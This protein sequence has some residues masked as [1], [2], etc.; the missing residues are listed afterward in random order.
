MNTPFAP[1]ADLPEDREF[2]LALASLSAARGV[3]PENL[4]ILSE[5]VVKLPNLGTEFALYKVLDTETGESGPVV[6]SGE[7]KPIDHEE[8]LKKERALEYEKRGTMQP[9][10]YHL[11]GLDEA[12]TVPVLIQFAVPEE[13]VDKSK[14]ENV[15]S[16]A[17]LS[18]RDQEVVDRVSQQ[19]AELF[20]ETLA[21]FGLETDEVVRPSGPF[22]STE[23]PAEVILKLSKDPRV[24]F[25]GPDQ[26][27]EILDYPTIPDSLP[28][29]RTD[30]V[31][32]T[33]T[34]GSGVK[35]AV[36]E[37][38]T[39]TVSQSC[40]NIGAIRTTSGSGSSHMTK[41][42]GIIGNRYN[43]GTCSGPWEGYAPEA[44]VLVANGSDY[45]D[46][47]QWA[48][49][50]GVN[51]V[52][53]SWHFGDEETSGS[54][55]SRD[56]YFDYWAVHYPYPAVFTSAGN[57]APGDFA[58]G[59]GYNFFGVGNVENDGDGDR[60]ND[61]ISSSSSYKNPASP[62]GDREIPEIAAPGSRHDLLGSSFGGTSCATPVAASIAALLMSANTSLKGW[63]EAIRVILLAT[64]NYQGA[65]GANWSKY[66]EGKD[67]TGMI[68]TRYAYHTAKRR[69]TGTTAQFRAHDYGSIQASDFSGG[70]FTK[71]W[72]AKT[73]TTQSRIRVAFMWNSKTSAS[74]SGPTS[75]VLDADLDLWVYDPSMN[76]V[77][78]SASYDSNYEFVEFTPQQ[79]GNYT[80]K[81]RGWS[82]PSSFWSY[83]GVAWTTHYDLCP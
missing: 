74:G 53:M 17:E 60:C 16:L 81:I 13:Q 68:N 66:A 15:D 27:P 69:E 71:T 35:I 62:Y 57:G 78:V 30:W 24:V 4:L 10:L 20:Y 32:D 52:T 63:P 3:E 72:K 31:H 7:G 38:G 1:K 2:E 67:G 51:V 56:V 49:S 43:G 47:Y 61:V 11:I 54:L 75:S 18:A 48:K 21:L 40:F 55:H 37:W 83:Y 58:S 46:R 6:L 23:L 70:F 8:L 26:E 28:T 79:A 41:S 80:I 9:E 65:D 36:L 19:T 45:K 29:T 82:V 42:V 25:I 5:I 22:V 77:A 34:K 59:K 39:L 76:L 33:G 64:A 73:G 50:Q 12:R 44:T 14:T